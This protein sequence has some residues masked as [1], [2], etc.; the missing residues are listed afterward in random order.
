MPISE[1]ILTM[2]RLPMETPNGEIQKHWGTTRR[3]MASQTAAEPDVWYLDGKRGGAS[4][5]HY[6][7][8][9]DNYFFILKG[10]LRV[11]TRAEHDDER[12]TD[13][14]QHELFAFSFV[15]TPN[16]RLFP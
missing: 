11:T 8:H 4:S 5:L 16:Q 10:W 15:F 13:L 2:L 14:R 7:R 3:I 9:K 12:T 6:H 1:T